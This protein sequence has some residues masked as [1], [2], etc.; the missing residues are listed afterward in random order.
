MRTDDTIWNDF[1]RGE[2]YALTQIYHQ[3]GDFLFGYG[4]KFSHDRDLV[5]DTIQ[6]LFFDLIRSRENL[7]YTNSIRFY[8][9]R[10]FRRKL[11]DNL[12]KI[13][14]TESLNFYEHL[15]RIDFSFDDE[16][17]IVEISNL[18]ERVVQEN[19]KELNPR[20]REILYYRFCC[21]MN[22]EE[23]C[24]IMSI[25]YDSAR[26]LVHRALE[27]LKARLKKES[28]PGCILE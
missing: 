13:Q 21:N 16:K 28:F 25:K 19:L 27:A 2:M 7:G 4:M 6:D 15:P 8:L 1:R 23:I 22:Y 18:R 24:Q 12:Q 5:K 3:Y 17:S 11:V 9:M 20:Q 26:K 14:V 10:S